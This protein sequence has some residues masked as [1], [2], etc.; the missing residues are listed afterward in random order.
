MPKGDK[1][2]KV[3]DE[4]LIQA[5]NAVEGNK[6]LRAINDKLDELFNI[7]LNLTTVRARKNKLQ[8]IGDI[9]LDDGKSVQS[10]TVLKGVSRYH[11]LEDGGIWIKSDVEKT[12]LLDD[13]K[14][15][16]ENITEG[17]IP[18]DTIDRIV[19]KSNSRLCNLY[20]S[21]DVH[22]GALMWD[23]ETGDRNWNLKDAKNTFRSGIDYLVSNSPDTDIGIV[24]D[25]G[26]LTEIDDFKNMTPHSGNILDVDSRYSKILQ[27]AF[28][29]M[30][31]FVEKALEKHN[32]VHFINISGNHDITTGHAVRAFVRAWFRN[33][34]RVVVD[35]SPMDIKYFCFGSTL[36]GFAHGDG[37]KMK[38][39][40][41]TMAHDNVDVWSETKERYFHFG[42]SH[43]DAVVDGKL[44]K[45]ES[46]RNIA[47]LNHWA[48]HKGFRRN[49][50]TM[51]SITYCDR[52]GEI[53]RSTY[54]VYME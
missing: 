19:T 26:D 40:G 41:E 47:P 1:T 52:F 17:I 21:N 20:I 28:E 33:N 42:H 54:N 11:Q 43:K 10:G 46:H 30:V 16:I 51:K 22:I 5:Y 31:Y 27:T 53:S 24:C 2:K 50:G 8:S 9:P 15:A 39:C 23:D 4:Q 36:L 3:T 18:I 6:T 13:F 38:D 44:C 7:S 48:S 37:L 34:D 32:E 29:C 49:A 35:D 14:E 45:A 25:L 12:K